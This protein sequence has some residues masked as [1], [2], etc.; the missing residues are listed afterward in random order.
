MKKIYISPT[1]LYADA[2]V[3]E[4]ICG[5]PT[6]IPGVENGGG[7]AEDSSTGLAHGRSDGWDDDEDLW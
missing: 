4:F 3:T 6:T 1:T 7:P 2:E 5:S